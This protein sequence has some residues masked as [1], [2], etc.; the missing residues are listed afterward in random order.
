MNGDYIFTYLD[1]NLPVLNLLIELG[2]RNQASMRTEKRDIKKQEKPQ[3]ENQY[4]A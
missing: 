4:G 3:N 1:M 2:E